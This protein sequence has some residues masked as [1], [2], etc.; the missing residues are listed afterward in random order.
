MTVILLKLRAAPVVN[1]EAA[2]SIGSL[3][4]LLQR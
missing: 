3:M 1:I 4:I 2:G